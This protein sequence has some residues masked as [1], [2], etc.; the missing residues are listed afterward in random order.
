MIRS[1]IAQDKPVRWLVPD[2]VAQLI[3]DRG[4]YREGG[5]AS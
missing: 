1:R 2:P 5:E 3:A 4:L